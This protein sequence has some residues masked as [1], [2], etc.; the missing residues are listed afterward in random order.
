MLE[1]TGMLS[2]MLPIVETIEIWSSALAFRPEPKPQTGSLS[3]ETADGSPADPLSVHMS[4]SLCEEA[5]QRNVFAEPWMLQ[6]AGAHLLGS[7]RVRVLVST[8][9]SKVVGIV[10]VVLPT[11]PL[12]VLPIAEVWTHLHC[13][14]S[15]PLVRAGGVGRFLDDLF[16]WLDR[17]NV[18]V[19]RW[20]RLSLD[21]SFGEQ[22]FAYLERTG[23][24]SEVVRST[25]RPMLFAAALREHGSIDR[26]LSSKRRRKVNRCRRRLA[27][28]GEVTFRSMERTCDSD[29]WFS[30]FCRLEASGWKGADGAATALACREEEHAFFKRVF[31]EAARRDQ[32]SVHSLEL[33]GRPIAMTVNY[34]SGD[35]LWA[36]K[37]AYDE[38]Y[39]RFGPGVM[40]ELEGTL[41]LIRTRR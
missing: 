15:T 5:C 29:W 23:R 16:A 14:E 13:F 20:P 32:L 39:A 17:H 36:Y 12:G 3:Y 2:E 30:E 41:Q 28:L 18:S 26:V 27:E 33:D 9:R 40:V 31:F 7:K 38:N 35:G 22:L 11:G 8:E 25:E 24:A 6:A 34:R 19:L 10:P 21:G 37:T 1:G 4:P